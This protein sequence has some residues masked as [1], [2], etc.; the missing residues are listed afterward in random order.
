MIKGW[1]MKRFSFVF[2][3]VFLSSSI[4]ASDWSMGMYGSLRSEYGLWVNT[5]F[6]EKIGMNLDAGVNVGQEPEADNI[7]VSIRAKLGLLYRPFG[8]KYGLILNPM[9]GLVNPS[10]DDEH[11]I[12]FKSYGTSIGGKMNFAYQWNLIQNKF[13]LRPTIGW[14]IAISGG[15][16]INP[17]PDIQIYIGY[18]F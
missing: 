14:D 11:V 4:F 13:I 12:G 8:N 18:N 9:I 3:L 16:N 10:S 2:I 15:F 17:W 1:P 7:Q 5:L 6:S